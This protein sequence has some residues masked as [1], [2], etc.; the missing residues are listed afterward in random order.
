ML[1]LRVIPECRHAQVAPLP[2]RTSYKKR[3][4]EW[5]Y[6]CAFLL[7]MLLLGF[8]LAAFFIRWNSINELFFGLAFFHIYAEFLAF[9]CNILTRH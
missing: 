2:F 5:G 9:L 6:P 3:I 7:T 4:E 1:W 8:L